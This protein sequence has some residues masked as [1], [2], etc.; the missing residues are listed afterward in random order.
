MFNQTGC[1]S[2]RTASEDIPKGLQGQRLDSKF[3][4]D[5]SRLQSAADRITVPEK[6]QT[7][8]PQSMN[9][10]TYVEKRGSADVMKAANSGDAGRLSLMVQGSPHELF[11]FLGLQEK[12]QPLSW[13]W[14]GE[15]DMKTRE[16]SE[17]PL[18][19]LWRWGSW[20]KARG[21]PLEVGKMQGNESFLEPPKVP[22]DSWSTEP[23]DNKFASGKP[24]RLRY[25]GTGAIEN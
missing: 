9:V 5:F 16:V 12:Q 2:R 25:F 7:W 3:P 20:A 19:C 13:L 22:S 6:V 18:W 24:L 17:T 15:K 11:D 10:V 1:T 23:Q 21:Q 14:P 4:H 8:I